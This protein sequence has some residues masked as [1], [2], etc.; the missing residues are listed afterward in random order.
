MYYILVPIYEGSAS[1][2]NH[3]TREKEFEHKKHFTID[4]FHYIQDDDIDNA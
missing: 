1:S 2:L 4:N 3:A